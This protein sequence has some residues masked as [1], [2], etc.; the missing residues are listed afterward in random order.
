MLTDQETLR[1][2]LQEEFSSKWRY[3]YELLQ[4]LVAEVNFGELLYALKLPLQIYEY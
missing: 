2:H 3:E 4:L 1:A